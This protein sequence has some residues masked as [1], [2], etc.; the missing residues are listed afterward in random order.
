MGTRRSNIARPRWFARYGTIPN[1][2]FVPRCTRVSEIAHV[3]AYSNT[4]VTPCSLR[5][6]NL[7]QQWQQQHW[8]RLPGKHNNN[9]S[10]QELFVSCDQP[11]PSPSSAQKRDPSEVVKDLQHPVLRGLAPLHFWRSLVLALLKGLYCKEMILWIILFMFS[12]QAIPRH[13]SPVCLNVHAQN[14]LDAV[15]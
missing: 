12:M 14:D 10:H 6:R 9:I 2:G 5:L 13:L 1:S 3:W 11:A 7:F 15:R 8:P 4:F